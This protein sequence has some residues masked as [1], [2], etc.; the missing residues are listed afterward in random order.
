MN[1]L[2]SHDCMV[3]RFHRCTFLCSGGRKIREDMPLHSGAPSSQGD[4]GSV[5]FLDCIVLRSCIDTDPCSLLHS[6]PSDTFHHNGRH[7]NPR[8]TCIFRLLGHKL[9]CGRS[10]TVFHNLD[11]VDQRDILFRRIVQSS[12]LDSHSLPSYGDTFLRSCRD[13]S[14]RSS[15]HRSLWDRSHCKQRQSIP[16][17]RRTVR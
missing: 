11:H 17:R 8:G 2:Q 4:S 9:N 3:H 7:G 15:F 16:V 1:T 6:N 10:R 5:L 13:T 14:G 12:P